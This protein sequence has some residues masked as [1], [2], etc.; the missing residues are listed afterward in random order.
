MER[1]IELDTPAVGREG[2][3]NDG[4][5]AAIVLRALGQDL[6]AVGQ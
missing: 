5:V 6:Y 1:L 4:L 2:V 3:A